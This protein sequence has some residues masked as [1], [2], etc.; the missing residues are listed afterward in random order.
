MR[1][2]LI[3]DTVLTN[4]VIASYW[5]TSQADC[6]FRCHENKKCLSYNYEYTLA[7]N[8]EEKL[9]LCELNN[10]TMSSCPLRKAIKEGHGYF[11]EMNVIEKKVNRVIA[12]CHTFKTHDKMNYSPAHIHHRDK[13]SGKITVKNESDG[14]ISACLFTHVLTMVYLGLWIREK[15]RSVL[16]GH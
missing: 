4:N 2:K 11:G 1:S 15:S 14:P 7:Y 12:I 16:F 9:G 13:M 5:V 8:N 10:K 6:L 3:L